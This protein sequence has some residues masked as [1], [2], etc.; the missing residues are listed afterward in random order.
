MTKECDHGLNSLTH[1]TCGICNR[2][3]IVLRIDMVLGWICLKC[4]KDRAG[5]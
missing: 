3:G 1:P 4:D 5:E 2:C